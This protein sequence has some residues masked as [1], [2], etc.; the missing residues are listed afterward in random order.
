MKNSVGFGTFFFF[1][2]W[3]HMC[4]IQGIPLGTENK[5]HWWWQAEPI[6][7]GRD[8]WQSWLQTPFTLIHIHIPSDLLKKIFF[9]ASYLCPDSSNLTAHTCWV[10]H[11]TV[12]PLCFHSPAWSLLLAPQSHPC[13]CSASLPPARRAS[14]PPIIHRAG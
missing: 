3:T 8:R 6:T 10:L 2:F 1:F 4:I 9:P 14:G 13:G 12:S 7:D 11:D 5:Y